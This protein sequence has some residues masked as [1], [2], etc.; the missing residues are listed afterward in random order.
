MYKTYERM[1]SLRYMLFHTSPLVNE[2]LNYRLI[3]DLGMPLPKLLAVGER[4][5]FF[6]LE[7]GYL[8]TEFADGFRNGMDFMPRGV[9]GGE[10]LLRLEFC[11]RNLR[12]LARIHDAGIFHR[13]FNPGNLLWRRLPEQDADGNHL[14]LL[15]IDLANCRRRPRFLLRHGVIHD[16]VMFFR[17]FDF[18]AAERRELMREY[19]AA[20]QRPLHRLETLVA[21][22][23]KMFKRYPPKY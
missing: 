10:R 12:R 4:R 19:H 11:R 2:A 21:L 5:R 9:L 6:W 20:A 7:S 14:E 17:Y 16:L 22:V 3:G 8:V 23:E 18:T 13:G 15:W 1:R